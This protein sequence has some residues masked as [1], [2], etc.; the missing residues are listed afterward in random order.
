MELTA[1][2]DQYPEPEAP[3]SPE[4]QCCCNLSQTFR[5]PS[6]RIQPLSAP[7]DQVYI[8][9]KPHRCIRVIYKPGDVFVD[10]TPADHNNESSSSDDDEYWFETASPRRPQIQ[11][12][13]SNFK[14]DKKRIFHKF[15]PQAKRQIPATNDP[16]VTGFASGNSSGNRLQRKTIKVP[17]DDDEDEDEKVETQFVGLDLSSESVSLSQNVPSE[18]S[19]DVVD[20]GVD[21]PDSD[22]TEKNAV[23]SALESH[24]G[25]ILNITADST[26]LK[27]KQYDQTE[28][29]DGKVS[30]RLQTSSPEPF[31]G[32]TVITVPDPGETNT[33]NVSSDSSDDETTA[34]GETTPAVSENLGGVA[35]VGFE[36]EDEEDGVVST[37]SVHLEEEEDEDCG[38][39]SADAGYARNRSLNDLVKTHSQESLNFARESK[40]RSSKRT[41]PAPRVQKPMLFFI[42]GLGGSADTWSGQLKYFSSEL[43]YECVA[44]DLLG[45]GFSSA[46]DRPKAYSFQKL[47]RDTVTIFDHFT[48]IS[49]MN[50]GL[51]SP[52]NCV[53]ICHA[54]GSPIGTAL[55]RLRPD[56]VKSLVMV[57]CGGPTPLAPPIGLPSVCCL[58][59]MVKCSGRFKLGKG[60][61]AKRGVTSTAAASV[62]ARRSRTGHLNRALDVPSYV[63]NHVVMGQSW[64]EGK[65]NILK[66][67]KVLNSIF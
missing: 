19:N 11:K 45:H 35:N 44:T 15:E 61:P 4:T 27:R 42:H 47:L 16:P 55:T 67:F 20:N 30:N 32:K 58:L 2:E 49:V 62:A 48:S 59:P 54:Y 7:Q 28:E 63:L 50:N 60:S 25:L 64:P 18:P 56:N 52:R 1:R 24:S 26:K 29:D 3:Q 33:D 9:I 51:E 65:P 41:P 36:S 57:A 39:D 6:H 21:Q 10:S 8:D 38:D 37:R 43:S 23:G 12:Q 17:T 14:K 22:S 31:E 66:G 46:P 53:V 5:R 13:N 34:A 40:R